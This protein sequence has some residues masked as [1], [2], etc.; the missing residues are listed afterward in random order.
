MRVLTTTLEMTDPA[1]QRPA[2]P[3]PAGVRIEEATAVTP[4]FARFLYA[5]VGGPWTWVDRLTWSREQWAG[6]LAAPGT[7]FFVAYAEGVPAGYVELTAGPG[8]DEVEIRYFGLA[9]Q[10]IGRGV[11]GALLAHGIA[12]AWSAPGV[13]RVWVHTCSLD[14]PAALPNYEARGLRVVSAVESDEPVPDAPLG[15]WQSTTGLPR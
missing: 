4:E 5:V 2:R 10:F 9:E 15:A 7:R 13:R 11:G 12:A 6:E 1:Q 14:G 3:L 8:E